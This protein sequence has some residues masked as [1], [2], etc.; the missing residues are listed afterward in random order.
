MYAYDV[1]W[2][3]TEKAFNAVPCDTVAYC[4]I[5]I[6]YFLLVLS[7]SSVRYFS[8]SFVHSYSVCLTM[9]VLL[10]TSYFVSS[11]SVHSTQSHLL[12]WVEL[13]LNISQLS[14]LA[15]ISYLR[16]R[17]FYS[18]D[19]WTHQQLF[20]CLLCFQSILHTSDND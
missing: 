20:N 12:L 7:V 14:T 8:A 1:F 15:Q 18:T 2:G 6:G 5:P 17:R 16:L 10:R 4:L 3:K 11:P 9:L 13:L 19:Y